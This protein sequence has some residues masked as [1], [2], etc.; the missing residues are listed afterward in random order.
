MRHLGR[1]EEHRRG[2]GAGR[3]AGPAPDAGRGVEGP[4]RSVFGDGKVVGF[5]RAS[6]VH[7]HE[8]ARF[9]DS[10]KGATIDDQVP[11]YGKGARPPRLDPDLGAVLE[12]AHVELAG[13]D[14][15]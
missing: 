13:G 15:S 9:D 11:D 3:D 10:V 8:S 5:G 7:R 6:S 4:L 14:P 12:A 2:V 1:G